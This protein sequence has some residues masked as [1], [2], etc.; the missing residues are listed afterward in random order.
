MWFKDPKIS[1]ETIFWKKKGTFLTLHH[2]RA[3]D[4]WNISRFAK[5]DP[6]V[7]ARISAEREN[8][9]HLTSANRETSKYSYAA[10]VSSA[11]TT[12]CI[13]VLVL[14]VA[15]RLER[16]QVSRACSRHTTVGRVRAR[17]K[18]CAEEAAALGMVLRKHP[19]DKQEILINT[20]DLCRTS[21]E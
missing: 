5:P 16:W 17:S 20:P 7:L 19:C 13:Y 9:C 4:C 2:F 10:T 18:W 1:I 8:I 3:I 11:C 21:G 15:H 6:R 12:T 14:R